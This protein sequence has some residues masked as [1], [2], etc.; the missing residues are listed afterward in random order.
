MAASPEMTA[1]LAYACARAGRLDR[2]RGLLRPPGAGRSAI[3][4]AFADR[5]GACRLRQC[6]S[7]DRMAAASGEVRA[8]DLSWLAVRP[9]FDA[10]RSDSRF[11][12]LVARIF[13]ERGALKTTATSRAPGRPM[14]SRVSS[15]S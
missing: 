15:P 4:V 9:V 7:G 14:R 8:A 1:A 3:R 6:R 2:A 12:A 13:G 11:N 5:A 10:L